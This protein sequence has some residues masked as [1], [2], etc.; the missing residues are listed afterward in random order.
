MTLVPFVVVNLIQWKMSGKKVNATIN[1]EEE[2]TWLVQWQKWVSG[3]YLLIYSFYLF[4][5]TI[6]GKENKEKAIFMFTVPVLPLLRI[7][8]INKNF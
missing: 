6:I 5:E 4:N 1:E 3:K 2:E 8:N 7:V